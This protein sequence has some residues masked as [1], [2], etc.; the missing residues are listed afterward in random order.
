MD[1]DMAIKMVQGACYIVY[2]V[3]NVHQESEGARILP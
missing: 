1:C 3:I 2:Y